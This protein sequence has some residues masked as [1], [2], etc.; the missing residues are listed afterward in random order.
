MAG[1]PAAGH[2]ERVADRDRAAIHIQLLMRNAEL[3]LAVEHL[4][5]EGFV[6]FP[7]IDIVDRQAGPF[8]QFRNSKDRSMAI[9]IIAVGFV[10]ALFHD[11]VL[12]PQTAG[13]L[14]FLGAFFIVILSPVFSWLWPWLAKFG[15]NP[16]KPTKSAIGLI[17]GGLAFLPMVMGA[18]AAGGGE[19]ASVWWLVAAYFILELGE[20]SLSPVGLSAVTQL[21]VSSVVSVMMGAW[22]LATAYSEVLAAELAKLSSID[23]PS[24]GQIDFALAAG[25]Y[26]ELFSIMIWIG[27]GSGIIYLLISPLLKRGMHGVE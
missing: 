2:A 7:Q 27:V 24:D 13:S 18:N 3:V 6:Q 25:K 26:S 17:L 14:T 23:L 22:F 5:C 15:L 4:A 19:L 9:G 1:Q 16:S 21:S 10:I 12:T 8:Q 11:I 20:L